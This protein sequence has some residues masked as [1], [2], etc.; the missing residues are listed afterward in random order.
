MQITWMPE[1]QVGKLNG[2]EFYSK[3]FN[4]Y[5]NHLPF[6]LLSIKLNSKYHGFFTTFQFAL[7]HSVLF[8]WLLNSFMWIYTFKRK[9][10]W[11]NVVFTTIIGSTYLFHFTCTI[12]NLVC[13]FPFIL[14]MLLETKMSPL[15]C[16]M[17]AIL[18]TLF[19][20][21][22]EITRESYEKCCNWIKSRNT[23]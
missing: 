4:Q 23:L 14:Q 11:G 20:L 17:L 10:S 7:F 22:I 5:A 16:Q 2:F 1:K 3:L 19:I 12:K 6:R 13:K 15:I 18:G 8:L 9:K 21:T